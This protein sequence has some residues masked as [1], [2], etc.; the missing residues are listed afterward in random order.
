MIFHSYETVYQ[1]EP[2]SA[3]CGR[4]I[5]A[6]PFFDDQHYNAAALVEASCALRIAKRPVEAQ[7]VRKKGERPEWGI[8]VDYQDI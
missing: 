1:S 2:A 5:L 8:V 3:R 4:P 7:Q 6:L